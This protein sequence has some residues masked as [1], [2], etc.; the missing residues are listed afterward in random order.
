MTILRGETK[1][2]I[3]C[4]DPETKVEFKRIAA[5]FRTFEDVIKWLNKNYVLFSKM[6]PPRPPHGG[7]L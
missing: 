5:E 3:R 7:I 4:K 6:A 2:D 1:I